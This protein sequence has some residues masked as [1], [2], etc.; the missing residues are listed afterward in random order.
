MAH[1][2]DAPTRPLFV[3]YTE[4]LVSRTFFS[5]VSVFAVF[6]TC[7][8]IFTCTR[9]REAQ[10]MRLKRFVFARLLQNHFICTPCYKDHPGH[11]QLEEQSGYLVNSSPNVCSRTLPNVHGTIFLEEHS[12]CRNFQVERTVGGEKMAVPQSHCL[13]NDI[14]LRKQAI[15]LNSTQGFSIQKARTSQD[16]TLG[17]VSFVSRRRSN[18][19]T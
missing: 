6:L 4:H 11:Q 8:H 1:G 7:E 15:K 13:E 18:H 17:H 5:V 14:P 2:P 3:L 16:G 9:V 12:S 10:V 19:Q